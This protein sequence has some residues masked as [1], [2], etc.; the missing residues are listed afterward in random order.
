M[1]N[2]YAKAAGGNWSS[3]NTWSATSSAGVDNAGPPTNVINCVFDSGAVAKVSVDTA[4]CVA[5]TVTCQSASNNLEFVAAK[6]LAVS[7]NVTFYAGM[8]ITGTGTLSIMSSSNLTLGV[9]NIFSGLLLFATGAVPT[10]ADDWMVTGLFTNGATTKVLNGYQITCNGGMSILGAISGSTNIILGGGTWSGSGA[11]SNNLTIQPEAANVIVSGSVAYNTGTLTYIASGSGKTVTTTGSTLALTSVPT[12]NTEG[13]N[14][15][16]ISTT[17]GFTLLSHLTCN[18]LSVLGIAPFVGAYNITCDIFRFGSSS[19]NRTITF[20]AGVTLTVIIRL[21][22]ASSLGCILT[23]DTLSS[24]FYL[25]YQ[26]TQVNCNVAGVTFTDV[27]AS[28]SAIPIDNW[29]DADEMCEYSEQDERGFGKGGGCRQNINRTDSER[30][31]GNWW[32]LNVESEDR[33]LI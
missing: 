28:G 32:H 13:I 24:P 7:G 19:V 21:L 27:D 17:V 9:G 5:K 6:A 33:T 31:S 25:N 4:T 1:A 20:N 26:G 16:T 18:I 12:L 11:I 30:D 29:W 23:S 14:W 3:A 15:S 2:L 10:L 8:T 22:I